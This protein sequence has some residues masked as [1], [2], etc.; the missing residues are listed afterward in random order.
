MDKILKYSKFSKGIAIITVVLMLPILLL[1]VSMGIDFSYMYYVK[2]QLQVAADAAALA[3]AALITDPN[4]LIQTNARD[5]AIEFALKNKAAG[6]NV[7]VITDNSNTS[8]NTNDITVGNWNGTQY[9]PNT[10]PVNTIE[11]IPK[12]MSGLSGNRGPVHLFIGQVFNMSFM[13]AKASAIAAIKNLLTLLVLGDG[14]CSS[15]DV[16]MTGSA[17]LEAPATIQVNGKICSSGSTS[18]TATGAGAEVL[19]ECTVE[20]PVTVSPT[21]QTGVPAM[22]DPF[23]SLP[24]PSTAG[25]P[26]F[27]GGNYSNGAV[28]YPGIYTNGIN[29][30]GTGTITL[31]PGI[32]ITRKGMKF[33]NNGIATGNGVMIYNESGQ[34]AFSNGSYTDFTPP[35]SGTYSGISLFQARSNT[36][37]VKFTGGSIGAGWHK[38]LMYIPD[39]ELSLTGNANLLNASVITKFISMTG[40]SNIGGTAS[41]GGGGKA[42]LVK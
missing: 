38:G 11:V 24:A 21:P 28:L 13:S 22:A 8:S 26:T 33:S 7:E 10:T 4:D 29:M 18:I 23:S 14:D 39:A 19:V 30:S 3:G 41:P 27:P 42:S 25:M 34:I 37:D 1:F 32:Y 17:A 31:N 12:R 35:S 6:V 9:K 36:Q 2:N 16:T 15:C 40:P 20:G 5:R